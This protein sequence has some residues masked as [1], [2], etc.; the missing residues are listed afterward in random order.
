MP[1]DSGVLMTTYFRLPM[2]LVARDPAACR[3]A[4]RLLALAVL[5]VARDLAPGLPAGCFQVIVRDFLLQ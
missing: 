2:D 5:D 1:R 3:N 4:E